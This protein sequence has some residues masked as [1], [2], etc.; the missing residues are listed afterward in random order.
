MNLI[1]KKVTY[2]DGKKGEIIDQNGNI[3]SIKVDGEVKNCDI[4]IAVKNGI[5]TIDDPISRQEV[6]DSIKAKNQKEVEYNKKVEEANK[7]YEE[8]A[9]Q[10]NEQ[11]NLQTGNG[12][13]KKNLNNNRKS[14]SIRP[15]INQRRNNGK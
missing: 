10:A 8:R 3:C 1:N 5:L 6:L 9:K 14:G 2:N 15:A 13:P 7:A 11:S 4:T 12:K